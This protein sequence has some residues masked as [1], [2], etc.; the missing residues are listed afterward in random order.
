MKKKI[1]IFIVICLIAVLPS[2]MPVYAEQSPYVPYESYSYWENVSGSQRKIVHNRPM[3]ECTDVFSASDISVADFSELIDVCVDSKGNVYLLDTQSRITILDENYKLIREISV[4]SFDKDYQFIGAKSVFVDKNGLIYICDTENKRVLVCD[5]QG[6]GIDKYTLPDSPLIPEGFDFKPTRIVVNSKGNVYVLCEGSYYGAL[7]YS[8]EKEFIG[9]YGANTVTNGVLDS[10]QSLFRRMFPNNAKNS[11]SERALPFSFTDIVIDSQNFVYTATDNGKEGQIKKLSPGIGVNILNSVNYTDDEINLTFNDGKAFTQKIT[12]LDVD[13][14]GF[15]YCLDSGYGRIFVYS[16]KSRMITA[17]GGGMGNGTQKGTFANATGIC[18]NQNNQLLVCDKTNNT[19]TV[20]SCNEYGK[21]VL[22]LVSLTENGHYSEAK[23]GWQKVLES[24]KN[25]Q[26]AYTGMA[27]AYLAEEDYETSMKYAREGYDR[28]TYSIAFEN[29]RNEWLL[30]NSSWIFIVVGL[31]LVSIIVVSVVLK[32]KNITLIKNEN[33]KIMLGVSL[34]PVNSFEL[35]KDKRKGSVKLSIILILL[36]YVVSVMQT[37][38]GGFLFTVYDAATFNS[39]WLF[40][41]SAGLIVLWVVA[42]W[43]VCTLAGG[44][45]RMREILIVT[46]YSLLPL[47]VE[48]IAWIFL[49]NVLLSSEMVFLN[50][51]DGVAI[52][53]FVVLLTIGMLKIHDFSFARFVG[54]TTLTAI[55]MAAIIFL[56]ILLGILLQQFGG[57]I[58][59]LIMEFFL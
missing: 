47:I 59:T 11:K 9:F 35:I 55:G 21:S 42:N 34:H 20:F 38:K 12:G 17:F 33:I 48:R 31:I 52:L 37:L 5:E 4:V 43:L 49:S 16:P 19:L 58:K 15:I 29:Y 30:A 13:G 57:F 8:P 56:L 6:K 51:L 41:R 53:Y 27:R 22:E 25:L 45:G 18:I 7:L 23:K 10:I 14:N 2:L 44:N 54:T 1:F 40:V 46:S 24:D 26:V 50:I 3:F 28:E 39:F 36:F 32:K